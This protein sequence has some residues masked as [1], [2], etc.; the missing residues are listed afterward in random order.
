MKEKENGDKGAEKD[1]VND[2]MASYTAWIPT[3]LTEASPC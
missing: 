2:A 3:L 1:E